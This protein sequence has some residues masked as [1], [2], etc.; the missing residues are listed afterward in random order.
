MQFFVRYEMDALVGYSALDWAC[1]T[2]GEEKSIELNV[3]NPEE[4]KSLGRARDYK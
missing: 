2:R 3:G 1:S 4:K